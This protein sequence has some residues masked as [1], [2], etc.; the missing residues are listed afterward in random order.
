VDHPLRL[1][2]LAFPAGVLGF[3]SAPCCGLLAPAF[4]P[5]VVGQ[6]EASPRLLAV[7]GGGVAE[8]G[9][10]RRRLLR[11]SF[12]FVVGFAT[13][14]TLLGASTSAAGS[15]LLDHLPLLEKV[16]GI[17]M[18]VMGLVLLGRFRVFLP[19]GDKCLD[20]TSLRT[21]RLGAVGMGFSFAITWTPCTGPI[22]GSILAAAASTGT[23]WQGSTLLFVY[24]LGLGIPFVLMALAASA[25][26]R[27]LA[28]QRRHA[29]TFERAG[30]VFMLAIGILILI[31]GWQ[32]WLGPATSWLINHGWPPI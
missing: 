28:F 12:L 2:L 20:T 4:L 9:I 1:V 5:Y 16:A 26:E 8:V 24:S 18:I 30:G 3:A 13:F 22:L 10:V 27:A 25:G 15:F 19:R 21:T 29:R 31:G 14:F 11:N 23:V 32:A 7:T 17:F 6:V